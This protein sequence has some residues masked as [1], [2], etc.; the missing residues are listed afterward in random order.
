MASL[1][2][3]EE[4]GFCLV[5]PL[6]RSWAPKGQ[7]P[8]LLTQIDHHQRINVLGALILSPAGRR[9]RLATRAHRYAITGRHVLAFVQ[10]LLRQV[11]GPIVLI[12]DNA[13]IHRRRLV[14]EDLHTHPR[15]QVRYFPAYAPELNPAEFIW[16]QLNDYLAGRAPITLQS[17]FTLIH[18][19]LQ[20]LRVS[21]R[22][23]WACV[24]GADLRW[25]RWNHVR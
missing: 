9:I 18:A 4:S 25:T 7:T 13:P 1:V 11:P 12:W 20:R 2:F 10:S 22:R 19:G 14:Q 17:L 8:H 16:T 3:L 5:S 23:M 6:K 21:P 15:L 24:A